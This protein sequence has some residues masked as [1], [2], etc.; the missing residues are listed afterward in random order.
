MKL[1]TQAL[2][3]KRTALLLAASLSPLFAAAAVQP[4][5]PATPLVLA[6]LDVPPAVAHQSALQASLA[7]TLRASVDEVALQASL[8]RSA[9]AQLNLDLAAGNTRA[10]KATQAKLDGYQAAFMK[11]Q[12]NVRA[13]LLQLQSNQ[14]RT[15]TRMN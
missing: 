1:T 7:S 6:A 14:G 4:A 10:A 9:H 13:H 5:S 3:L 12:Q 11:A 8:I 2:H 15:Q